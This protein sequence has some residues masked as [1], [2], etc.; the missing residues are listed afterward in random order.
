MDTY[1][2]KL[3]PVERFFFG[4]DITFGKDNENYFI[5]SLYFPQQTTLLGTLRY[6][7]LKQ[8]NLLDNNGK[9]TN[10]NKEYELIGESG[11]NANHY[12]DFKAIKK[13][14]PVFIMGPD[15]EY[16]AQSREYGLQWREDEITGDKQQILFPLKL[17][18]LNGASSFSNNTIHFFEGFNAK[19]EIPD[20][21]V[22]ARNGQM[23]YFDYNSELKDSPMNGIFIPNTQ[24][25]I[26]LP[27]KEKYK[28]NNEKDNN[29]KGYYKQT[30]YTLLQ[31]YCFAFYAEM[32][33][34]SNDIFDNGFVK[35]GADQ[36]WF[37]VEVEELKGK[38]NKVE[39]NFVEKDSSLV[40]NIYRGINDN[41]KKVVLLSDCFLDNS[42]CNNEEIISFASISTVPFRYLETVD[43]SVKKGFPLAGADLKLM[44]IM[45][46]RT[47][48]K[49]GSVLYVDTAEQKKVLI[50]K[51]TSNKAFRQIG[52]NY[53][54]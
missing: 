34:K 19:T 21:L 54:I 30:G 14:S 23:R 41:R 26:R 43:S 39:E 11:F 9:V 3:T 27:K 48:L 25:G 37:R 6:Y 10:K 12:S 44:K 53:A 24:V 22:N 40:N 49:K 47:L 35:M 42:I 50:K 18:K 45:T 17:R 32:D 15:G 28:K 52:Y 7:L 51:I 1:L 29:E 8:N 2:I 5:K 36:S 13:L 16:F 20:L 4:S 38:D 46:Y 33:L 31:N